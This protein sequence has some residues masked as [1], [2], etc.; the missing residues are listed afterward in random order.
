MPTAII[1]IF[2]L[3]S[4]I[5]SDI[6]IEKSPDFRFTVNMDELPEITVIGVI[7]H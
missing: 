6:G 2:A 7:S 5:T 1:I 4:T 3:M